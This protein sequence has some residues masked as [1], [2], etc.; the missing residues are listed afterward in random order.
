ML[1]R[2]HI[3]R[4]R[5]RLSA[6]YKITGKTERRDLGCS[7]RNGMDGGLQQGEEGTGSWKRENS[8]I[9]K[10]KLNDVMGVGE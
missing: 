3:S 9:Q 4:D 8:T 7:Q 2:S 5:E 6:L 10:L 1:P